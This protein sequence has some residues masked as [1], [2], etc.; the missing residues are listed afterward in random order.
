[1]AGIGLK[2]SLMLTLR[3]VMAA[4]FSGFPLST[5]FE[6]LRQMRRSTMNDYL[7]KAG[8]PNSLGSWV[9]LPAVIEGLLA[10]DQREAAGRLYPLMLEALKRSGS[11]VSVPDPRMFETSAGLAAFAAK[12]W[13]EAEQHFETALRQADRLPHR[14]EQPEARR[15]YAGMLIDRDA[16]GDRDK[17]RVLLREAVAMYREI[18]MPKHQALAESSLGRL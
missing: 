11:L 10:N 12:R 4:R 13:Q 7:P 1:M 15:F 6:V 14:L 16:V 9:L 3:L 18:G 2:R 17:A 8:R 5:L